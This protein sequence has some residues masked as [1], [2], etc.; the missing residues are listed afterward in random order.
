MEQAG[1]GRGFTGRCQGVGEASVVG[2]VRLQQAC[3]AVV[4]AL[5]NSPT[6]AW[7]S[8]TRAENI[9]FRVIKNIRWGY[10]GQ[11]VDSL[12]V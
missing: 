2:A 12:T 6:H 8:E 3:R 5:W 1:S 10:I 11:G 7:T 4:G 9:L